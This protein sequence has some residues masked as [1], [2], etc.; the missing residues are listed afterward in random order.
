MEEGGDVILDRLTPEQVLRVVSAEQGG[1]LSW[2]EPLVFF[3][4]GR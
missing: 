1:C 2:T 4:L 3:R